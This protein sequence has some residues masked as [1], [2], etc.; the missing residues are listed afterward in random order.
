MKLEDMTG[1]EPLV[2]LEEGLQRTINY[3]LNNNE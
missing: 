3:Y 1:F 2:S